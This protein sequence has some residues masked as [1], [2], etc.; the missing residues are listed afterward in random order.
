MYRVKLTRQALKDAKLIAAT[1]LQNKVDKIITELKTNPYSSTYNMEKLKFDLNGCYS[2]RI[3]LQHRLIYSV[4]EKNKI[5][6]IHGMWTHY[7]KVKK[8]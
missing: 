8:Y 5:I 7:E 1:K 4:D 6:V 2:K 3:T